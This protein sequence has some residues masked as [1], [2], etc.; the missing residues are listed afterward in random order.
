MNWDVLHDSALAEKSLM[1]QN[2][3]VDDLVAN[4]S[5]AVHFVDARVEECTERNVLDRELAVRI[6]INPAFER[7]IVCKY[8]H[9]VVLKILSL[10]FDLNLIEFVDCKWAAERNQ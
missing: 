5:A 7:G 9:H 3:K 1:L 6:I 10:F 4:S 8:L 2:C